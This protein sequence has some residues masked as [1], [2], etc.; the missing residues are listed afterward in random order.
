MKTRR[1]VL[2]DEEKYK[3]ALKQPKEKFVKPKKN[4]ENNSL[5]EKRGRIHMEKQNL[6]TV[7]LRKYKKILGRKRFN[8]KEEA[9]TDTK[10]SEGISLN[11]DKNI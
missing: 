4:I 10:T 9:K 3:T 5:G 2:A 8:K 7:A 11:D 1:I 6:N